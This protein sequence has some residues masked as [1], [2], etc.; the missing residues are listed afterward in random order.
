MN[1]SFVI[2]NLKSGGAEKAFINTISI[3]IQAGHTCNLFL[4]DAQIDYSIP[5]NFNVEIIKKSI[6]GRGWLGKKVM[7][8]RL[9]QKLIRAKPNAVIS[10]LPFA[11]EVTALANPKNH[12]CRIANTL[13]AEIEEL[14][15]RNKSKAAKRIKKYKDIYGSRNLIAVSEGVAKDLSRTLQIKSKIIVIYNP[16]LEKDI[17]N[18]STQ[19]IYLDI[20][21][22]FLLYVG[23]FSQQK[24]LDVLL[25]AF[26]EIPS[27]YDLVMLTPQHIELIDMINSRGISHRVHVLGFKKNPY[28]YMSKSKLLVLTSDREG[29]PNVLVEALICG[30]P[31]VST[32]CPS[33]PREILADTSPSSLVPCGDLQSLVQAIKMKLQTS[34]KNQPLILTKF[35]PEKVLMAY[36]NIATSME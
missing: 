13:S 4:L 16:F 26:S 19:P 30:T 17:I 7:A 18:Q 5:E 3:L 35:N 36:E 8:A 1:F 2:T 10:T 11:D 12:H 33:G 22:P 20:K 28:A 23:R 31:V 14:N 9:K 15:L 6:F 25:D 27:E 24:R 29:L 34:Q 21:N 32:D